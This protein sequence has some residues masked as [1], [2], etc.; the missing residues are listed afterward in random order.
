MAPPK[1]QRTA[2]PRVQA[3]LNMLP[4][5]TFDEIWAVRSAIDAIRAALLP[6]GVPDGDMNTDQI[7]DCIF[8]ELQS[9]GLH[10][11]ITP[12]F[13]KHYSGPKIDEQAKVVIEFLARTSPQLSRLET[14]RLLS[15]YVRCFADWIIPEAGL[16]MRS[17]VQLLHRLPEAV[18]KAFPQYAECG[19][20]HFL[21]KQRG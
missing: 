9:R 10:P 1:K 5:M 17:M 2:T 12:V 19:L 7:L 20:L 18:N 13:R 15:I 14:R 3:V 16:S 8:R 11:P 21:I 6:V 4:L